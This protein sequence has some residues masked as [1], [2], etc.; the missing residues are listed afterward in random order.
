MAAIVVPVSTTIQLEDDRKRRL[1]RLK[2]GGMTY[3]DV[4]AR[5]LDDVDED[6]FRRR[7]LEWEETLAKSI[8]S[9]PRNQRL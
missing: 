2:V 9:N 4:I 5:L 8:R 3:D 1:A 6:A 7:A